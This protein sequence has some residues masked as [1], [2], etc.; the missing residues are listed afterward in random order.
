MEQLWGLPIDGAV[1]VGC[2]KKIESVDYVMVSSYEF[3][4]LLTS[5]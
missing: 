1:R 2:V 5:K 3:N 4:R